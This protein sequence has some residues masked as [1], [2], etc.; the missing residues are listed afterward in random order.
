MIAVLSKIWKRRLAGF[1][2]LTGV[3]LGAP[4]FAAT[5]E[6]VEA[7]YSEPTSAYPHGVLGDDEEWERL[8]IVVR[9][10]R[11]TEGGLFHGYVNVTYH[12]DAL[13]ETVYEDI[14]PRLWDVTGDGKP[15]VVVVESHQ[16]KGARLLIIE[17]QEDGNLEYLTA[18][19]YIGQRFRWLAPV[20]AAD[21]DGDGFIEIAFVDRPHLAKVLKVW[22]YT[23]ELFSQ[24]ATLQGVSNHRIGE[25]FITGGVRDCGAGPEMVIVDGSWQQIFAARLSLTAF[26]AQP[27]APFSGPASVEQ[28]L[29]CE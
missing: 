2:L 10:E 11:G 27:I 16:T 3:A 29:A 24:V 21:F 23:P 9:R 5:L 28:V 18:T 20:G 14:A 1:L 4:A 25:D 13:P 15:E 22:R 12:I 7:T 8:E 26:T 19:P 17:L 6:I